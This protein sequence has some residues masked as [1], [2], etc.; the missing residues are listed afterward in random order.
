MLRAASAGGNPY[1]SQPTWGAEGTLGQQPKVP[2]AVNV[3]FRS[4]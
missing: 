1:G 2:E 3:G 4:Q